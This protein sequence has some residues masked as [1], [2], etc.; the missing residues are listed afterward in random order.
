MEGEQEQE[1]EACLDEDQN[2][3]EK[4]NVLMAKDV[5]ILLI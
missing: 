2:K 4:K 1:A 3:Q 5:M